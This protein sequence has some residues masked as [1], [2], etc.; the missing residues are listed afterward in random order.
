MSDGGTAT[1][2]TPTIFPMVLLS[3]IMEHDPNT[4]GGE[5]VSLIKK[6]ASTV[7]S[8]RP[9]GRQ[10][11]KQGIQQKNNLGSKLSKEEQKRIPAHSGLDP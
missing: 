7:C 9:S 1:S 11:E 10:K 5:K 3:Q 6:K 2:S 4:D 8:W